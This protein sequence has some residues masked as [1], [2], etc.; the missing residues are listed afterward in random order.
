VLARS[1]LQMR[2]DRIATDEV[3]QTSLQGVW[4]GGDC[5]V[6]GLE[7][8]VEAVAHGKQS[9]LAIHAALSTH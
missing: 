9:A 6:G 4:A 3:G 2:G 5:R 1:G 7:L 8:T